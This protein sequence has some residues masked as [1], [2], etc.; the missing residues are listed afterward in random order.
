MGKPCEKPS[1]GAIALGLI[2]YVQQRSGRL[3]PVCEEPFARCGVQHSIT[4]HDASGLEVQVN[5]CR[6]CR[7]QCFASLAGVLR[8][9]PIDILILQAQGLCP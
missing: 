5:I 1:L 6:K 4:F 3:C 9:Q 7:K 2:K 8:G